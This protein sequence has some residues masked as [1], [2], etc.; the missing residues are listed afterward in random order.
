MCKQNSAHAP[1]NHELVGGANTR[2]LGAEVKNE[3]ARRTVAGLIASLS[4]VPRSSHF[5]FHNCLRAGLLACVNLLH[6]LF[7]CCLDRSFTCW[8]LGLCQREAFLRYG[9]TRFPGSGQS[10]IFTIHSPNGRTSS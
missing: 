7:E 6:A 8:E 9:C 3:I 2:R 1:V 10:R 5:A 4:E